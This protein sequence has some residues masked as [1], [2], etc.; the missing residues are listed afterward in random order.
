MHAGKI[1]LKV[2]TGELAGGCSMSAAPT[3]TTAAWDIA[4]ELTGHDVLDT[5]QRRELM[6][7]LDESLRSQPEAGEY[8]DFDLVYAR[9]LQL[10]DL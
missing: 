10:A 1:R 8:D 9:L 7:K 3:A 4:L 2:R 6:S 5:D